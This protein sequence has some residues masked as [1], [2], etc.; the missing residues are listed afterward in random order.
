M[1]KPTSEVKWKKSYDEEME[2]RNGIRWGKLFLWIG[3]MELIGVLGS[4]FTVV[5]I[6]SWYVGLTKPFFVPPN[7]LFGPVWTLLYAMLGYVGYKLWQSNRNNKKIKRLFLGQLVLNAV[8]SPVF[9]G[10]QE[11]LLALVIIV[12]L[13]V[14][15]LKLLITAYPN[16]RWVCWWLLP[17]FGWISFASL[18]NAS[19]AWLN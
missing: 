14:L 12:M 3:G 13:W 7:W 15:L 9:F 16:Q 6:E 1:A 18:L 4:I 17:Y 11:I 5:N 8:W 10:G 2:F 19:L